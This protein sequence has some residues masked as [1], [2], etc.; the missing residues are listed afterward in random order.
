MMEHPKELVIGLTNLCTTN[1]LFCYR[2]DL[3][4]KPRYFPI[5]KYKYLLE[6]LGPGLDILE[7]SGI[8]EPLLHPQFKEFVMLA[9]QKFSPRKLKLQL[10]S[11]GSLLTNELIN[12]L[13]EQ[14][15]SQVWISLNAATAKTYSSVMPGLNFEMIIQRISELRKT[16]D[17]VIPNQLSIMLTY[18]VTKA[19]FN[20]IEE[21]VDLGTKLKADRLAI[22][23]VDHLLNEKIYK[24]QQVVREQLEPILE[25]IE[26]RAKLDNR[27]ECAPRWVFWPDELPQPGQKGSK[28]IYCPNAEQVFGVYFSS[29]EVTPCCYTAA[30]VEN[31]GNCIG[32]IYIESIHDIWQKAKTF[33]K[34]L[35]KVDTAPFVCK[36]CTNYWGKR[37]IH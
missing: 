27:I 16:V 11:N 30:Y 35:N 26:A 1:C 20:E 13:I 21:F 12:F 14:R 36:K 5:D 8:G 22:R 37:W 28:S 24:E 29:G 17:D 31:P 32:N 10:V 25:R 15:F 33:S 3:H 19:N 2:R 18:V 4:L 34:S 23:N 7:Y 9:R 6:E